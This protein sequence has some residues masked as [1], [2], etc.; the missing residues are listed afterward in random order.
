[1][2]TESQKVTTSMTKIEYENKEI[3]RLQQKLSTE[4]EKMRER[5]SDLEKEIEKQ[6]SSSMMVVS[7]PGAGSLTG[8]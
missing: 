7:H 5:I 3:Q 8:G 1:M 2:Q 4:A 6:K